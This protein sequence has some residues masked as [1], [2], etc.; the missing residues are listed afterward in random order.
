MIT[1]LIRW[2]DETQIKTRIDI[3][4][5]YIQDPITHNL[6]WND[7]YHTNKMSKWDTHTK[8]QKPN[9]CICTYFGRQ[10]PS[11]SSSQ[12]LKADVAQ[13][14]STVEVRM[15]HDPPE[16]SRSVGWM[17]SDR[18]GMMGR[19]HC[20]SDS[21]L[22]FRFKIWIRIQIQIMNRDLDLDSDSNFTI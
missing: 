19:T 13:T 18:H 15:F 12:N 9:N 22:W 17:P 21:G 11:F 20:P 1:T 5:A 7:D 4:Q 3:R 2:A 8:K 6:T 16:P 14:H 10:T